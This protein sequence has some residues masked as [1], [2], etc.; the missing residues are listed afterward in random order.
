MVELAS[1]PPGANNPSATGPGA[2]LSLKHVFGLSSD[3]TSNVRFLDESVFLYPAGNQIVIYNAETKSQRFIHGVEAASPVAVAS[4]ESGISA[5][6]VAPKDRKYVA[7]AERG[8]RA[9]VSVFNVHTLKRT[10]ASLV[11]SDCG[12]KQ[13]VSLCFSYD[14]R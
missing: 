7:V 1:A 10:R 14:Q 8:E 4:G 2:I 9:C 13:F 12:S 3:V 11:S 5:I 6:A